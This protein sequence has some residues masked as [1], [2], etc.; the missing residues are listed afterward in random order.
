M[1]T[2]KHVPNWQLVYE[3]V[4]SLGGRASLKQIADYLESH[5]RNPSNARFEA[6][7][8]SVNENSRIHYT[9]GREPRRTDINH[10]YDVLFH[11]TDGSYVLYDASRHGVW[12][13]Y[14][15]RDGTRGVRLVHEPESL[16]DSSEP[17]DDKPSEAL[18]TPSSEFRLESHLRDYLAQNLG[19]VKGL[20]TTL[21]LYREN[22]EAIGIEYQTEVGRID[23]LATGDNNAFYVLELKLSKG[24]DAAVG[25]TLRYMAAVRS[26]LAKDRPVYG[27][28]VAST[29][30]DRLRYAVSEVRDRV[31]VLRYELHVSLEPVELTPLV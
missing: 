28:I 20:G 4:K 25:Q 8:L 23:I 31:F 22:D 14:Q 12:E 24:P 11:D 27:V 6:I 13:I 2:E 29:I 15:S 26:A 16:P 17:S 3:C 7:S 21:R 10:R 1:A 19:L 9:G 5:G 30:T 18:F